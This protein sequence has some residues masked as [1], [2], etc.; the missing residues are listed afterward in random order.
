[1]SQ[2]ILGYPRKLQSESAKTIRSLDGDKGDIAV[3]GNGGTWTVESYGGVRIIPVGTSL[4][5]VINGLVAGSHILQLGSGDYYGDNGSPT[6]P[7]TIPS[8]IGNLQIRGLGPDYTLIKSPILSEASRFGLMD[9]GVRPNS[10]TYGVKIFKS[11]SFTARCFLHRVN[12]GASSSGAGDGP[13]TGLILD[14]A[15]LLLAEQL[16]CAFCTSDGVLADSTASE[17]NTT[18]KFDMCSF[19]GNGGYGVRLENSLSVAE[20]NGGNMEQ[21]VSGEFKATNLNSV[22]IHG[23]DFEVTQSYSNTVEVNTCNPC[24]IKDCNFVRVSGTATRAININGGAGHTVEGNRI[25]G[26]GEVGV[27]RISNTTVNC[28]VGINIINNDIGYGWIEDYSRP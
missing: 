2:Q 18:L 5:G 24:S 8:T 13:A 3:S 12:I 15:G 16:S 20:F 19:V 7:L 22:Y 10:T 28:R 26:W 11:G 14:G 17:P 6:T 21:N 9:L 1:M 23:V 4:Q 25:S 27:V